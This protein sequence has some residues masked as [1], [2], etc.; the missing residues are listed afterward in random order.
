ME[1]AVIRGGRGRRERLARPGPA[2][3]S[4]CRRIRPN[5]SRSPSQSSRPSLTTTPS[6]P[7]WTRSCSR[8]RTTSSNSTLAR[9]PCSPGPVSGQS[10]RHGG[11]SSGPGAHFGDPLA[12]ACGGPVRTGWGCGGVR[13]RDR[14]G[15]DSRPRGGADHRNVMGCRCRRWRPRAPS[16]TR[17]E[18]PPR[19]RGP[20]SSA[21]RTPRHACLRPQVVPP[22]DAT[23]R[24]AGGG[25]A[26]PV[27][28]AG[29]RRD[30]PV[31]PST[32][33]G[34]RH[35]PALRQHPPLA[36][37]HHP[38]PALPEHLLPTRAAGRRDACPLSARPRSQKG[39]AR[40]AP[41]SARAGTDPGSRPTRRAA[42]RSRAARRGSDP[43][44]AR[45]NLAAGAR[46]CSRPVRPFRLPRFLGR[47]YPTLAD[48]PPPR[49]ADDVLLGR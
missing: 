42:A 25:G 14:H 10:V 49:F 26:S 11:G 31:W 32:L 34:P 15:A 4:C 33:G 24:R 45:A 1:C 38:P 43:H 9:R 17:S 23:V 13:W 8:R 2:P 41:G 44:G 30:E 29:R 5:R 40:P 19:A 39:S 16:A 27:E 46:R 18:R 21:G 22:I 28:P 12:C 20:A 35:S 6:I 47:R 3:W 48:P 36:L 37:P 7:R